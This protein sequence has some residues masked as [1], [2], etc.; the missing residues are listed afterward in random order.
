MAE[1]GRS[2]LKVF[3]GRTRFAGVTLLVSMVILL[4]VHSLGTQPAVSAANVARIAAPADSVT[5]ATFHVRFSGAQAVCYASQ[6]QVVPFSM[7]YGVTRVVLDLSTPPGLTFTINVNSTLGPAYIEQLQMAFYN[8]NY[9]SPPMVTSYWEFNSGSGYTGVSNS[10]VACLPQSP[11][12]LYVA[13]VAACG[14]TFKGMTVNDPLGNP[15]IP[16]SPGNNAAPS[17]GIMVSIS[18]GTGA[19][20]GQGVSGSPITITALVV[21]PVGAN[22]T[23]SIP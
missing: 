10:G 9:N 19:T 22:V 15:A 2:V 12:S 8:A 7:Y 3:V 17:A 5:N 6:C 11:A 23:I 20:S 21:A 14:T 4:G 16:I 18:G 13:L 1:S